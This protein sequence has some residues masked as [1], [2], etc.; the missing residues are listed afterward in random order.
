MNTEDATLSATLCF[1]DNRKPEFK[2]FRNNLKETSAV[3]TLYFG[4]F[5]FSPITLAP[6]P[7]TMEGTAWVLCSCHVGFLLRHSN[8]TAT[9]ML[10]G[11]AIELSANSTPPVH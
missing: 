5:Y 4:S 6:P 10:T 3:M 1:F 11:T 8:A 2:Q 9:V 7:R